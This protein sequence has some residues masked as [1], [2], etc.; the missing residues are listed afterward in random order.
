[1]AHNT[2]FGV[3]EVAPSVGAAL[4]GGGVASVGDDNDDELEAVMGH[5]AL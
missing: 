5:P 3:P 1:V 2:V 4:V